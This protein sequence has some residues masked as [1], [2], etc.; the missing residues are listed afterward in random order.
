M[1][2][3]GTDGGQRIAA[4]QCR[5]CSLHPPEEGE[6]VA[7]HTDIRNCTRPGAWCQGCGVRNFDIEMNM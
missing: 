2:E 5:Y 1:N 3:A 4:R 6:E 7:A